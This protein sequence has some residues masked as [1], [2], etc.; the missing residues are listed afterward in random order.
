MKP[1]K[2]KRHE[3]H[4]KQYKGEPRGVPNKLIKEVHYFFYKEDDLKSALSGLQ[5]EFKIPKNQLKKWFPDIY[6]KTRSL[7]E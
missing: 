3:Y 7:T 1:L 6:G 4:W 2:N 5:K